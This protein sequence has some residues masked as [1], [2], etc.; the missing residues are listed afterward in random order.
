MSRHTF[1]THHQGHPVEV[2]L[3]WDRPLQYFHLTVERVDTSPSDEDDQ[4]YVYCN[5]ADPDA[6]GQDLDYFLM[7]LAGLGIAIPASMIAQVRIDGEVNRGNHEVVHR[8]EDDF[9]VLHSEHVR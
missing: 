3:G 5:L 9:D 2:T 7:I 6:H 8:G 4:R 1:E